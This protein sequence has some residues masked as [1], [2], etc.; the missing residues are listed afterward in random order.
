MTLESLN[1]ETSSFI[2]VL[3]HSSDEDLLEKTNRFLGSSG[4]LINEL[5]L[6][7]GFD[8]ALTNNSFSKEELNN[9]N[10][11]MNYLEK[12][13][14]F[15]NDELGK[16][17]QN[18]YAIVAY[19]LYRRMNKLELDT[20]LENFSKLFE[21]SVPV[22]KDALLEVGTLSANTFEELSETQN[23]LKI[24]QEKLDKSEISYISTLGI[25]TGIIM[26]FTGVF[27]F[28]V[29]AFNNISSQ[30]I[31]NILLIFTV[32]CLGLELVLFFLFYCV[33]ILTSRDF[34]SKVKKDFQRGQFLFFLNT[35]LLVA[36]IVL[37]LLAFIQGANI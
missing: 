3:L 22:I 20:K 31:F 15:E 21:E 24:S 4:T 30:N 28:S 26:A 37:G 32:L 1:Q 36:I 10:K 34:L 35:I 18:F 6:D 11:S 25:F 13:L 14:T 23:N 33:S 12:N 9:M 7:Y 29:S 27:S 5:R 2:E 16:Q 8:A 19:Q 17:F